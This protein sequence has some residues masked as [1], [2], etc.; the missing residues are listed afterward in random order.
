[1]AIDHL[2]DCLGEPDYNAI[3]FVIFNPEGAL[4][5]RFIMEDAM[6]EPVIF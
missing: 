6:R 3:L 4:Y 1:M 2:R 5:L